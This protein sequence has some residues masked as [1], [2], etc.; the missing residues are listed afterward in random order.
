MRRTS[1]RAR[2]ALVAALS[3]SAVACGAASRADVVACADFL[4]LDL[5]ERAA[6]VERLADRERSD[7]TPSS[8]PSVERLTLTCAANPD[9]AISIAVRRAGS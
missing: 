1:A 5:G 6:W 2:A 9:W 7:P 4:Q 8:V 3:T